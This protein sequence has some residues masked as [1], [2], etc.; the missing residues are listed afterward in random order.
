MTLRPSTI[1]FI[2]VNKMHAIIIVYID[3]SVRPICKLSNMRGIQ[4][5]GQYGRQN[6]KNA[7]SNAYWFDN[8]YKMDTFDTMILIFLRGW[9]MLISLLYCMSSDPPDC[10][11]QD[12]Y[13]NTPINLYLC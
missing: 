8:A 2:K 10:C 3:R 12:G 13:Q 7:R 9:Y 5:G 1:L 6:E 11:K 4:N